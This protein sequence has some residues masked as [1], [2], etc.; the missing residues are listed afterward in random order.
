[1]LL[2]ATPFNNNPS[3]ILA[4]LRLFI[5][6]KKS[7]ITLDDNLAARFRTYQ[8]LFNHLSYVNR[9][10]NSPDPSKRENALKRYKQVFKDDDQIDLSKVKKRSVSLAKEIREVITPVLIRRNRLDLL[11]NP[12]YKKEI[13][14]LSKIDDPKE[15]FY[16]LTKINRTL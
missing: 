7:N 10:H 16:E 1:M 12:A 14:S 15:W 5:L 4:L 6:P 13:S 9:Y 11:G 2:T 8:A 3:D